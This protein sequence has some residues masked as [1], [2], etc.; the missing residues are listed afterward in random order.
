MTYEKNY[1]QHITTEYDEQFESRF[2]CKIGLIPSKKFAEEIRA[3]NW[4]R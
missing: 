4:R 3:K 1:M 2:L